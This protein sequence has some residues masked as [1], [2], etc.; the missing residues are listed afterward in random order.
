MRNRKGYWTFTKTNLI[1]IFC[2]FLYKNKVTKF[3]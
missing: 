1:I 3:K 2:Y